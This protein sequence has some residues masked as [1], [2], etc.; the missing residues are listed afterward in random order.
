MSGA[1]DPDCEAVFA[2]FGIDWRADGSG[3]GQPL[4][5]GRSPSVFKVLPR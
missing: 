5:D 3:S 2:A 4:G 1:T